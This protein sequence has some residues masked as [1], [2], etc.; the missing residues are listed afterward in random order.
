MGST[1][2]SRK[3]DLW[4]GAFI[5][6]C[7]ALTILE[8]TSYDIGELARMGPGYFPL[9]VGCFLVALGILIPLSPDPDE[10]QD[11]LIEEKLPQPAQRDRVRGMACIA[12]GIALF[13]ILGSSVG[14]L[15]AT[16]ALVFVSALGDTSN[17]VKSATILALAMT[18]FGAVVFSWALQLQF[19]MLR[20]G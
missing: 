20:W 19:P 3:R 11:E 9:M 16:F 10:V 2:F 7:G 4:G 12:G 6:L 18:A 13:I 1:I 5:A 17:S 15:P 14:F 8:A